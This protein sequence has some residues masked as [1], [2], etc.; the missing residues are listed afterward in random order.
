VRN[1]SKPNTSEKR[2]CWNC[3]YQAIGGIAFLGKC[4]WFSKSG[5]GEDK[6]IPASVVDAGCKY[7]K[8]SEAHKLL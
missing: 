2:N 1:G 8:E 5:K 6:E 3:A 4:T 7:Y